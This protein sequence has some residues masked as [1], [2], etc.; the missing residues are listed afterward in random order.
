[1]YVIRSESERG[2]WSNV[3]GWVSDLASATRFDST[4]Y[5]LP[6]SAGRDAQF[7]TGP[8]VDFEE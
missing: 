7:V 2:Y 3:M 6:I 8:R 1:M 5:D 4:D